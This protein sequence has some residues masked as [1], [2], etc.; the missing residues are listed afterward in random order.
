V[1]APAVILRPP[2]ATL[3]AAG[4]PNHRSGIGSASSLTPSSTVTDER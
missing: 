2:S 3:H 4:C 1:R